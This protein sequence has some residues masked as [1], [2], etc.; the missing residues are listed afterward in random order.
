MNPTYFFQGAA[1]GIA[2]AVLLLC[3]VLAMRHRRLGF[4]LAM[5]ELLHWLSGW[6]YAASR[7][8]RAADEIRSEVRAG[9]L[10]L[11]K[12]KQRRNE[13]GHGEA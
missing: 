8:A 7:I 3:A 4:F 11:Q 6:L 9:H 2:T 5:A 13:A 1:L 12:A 10:M